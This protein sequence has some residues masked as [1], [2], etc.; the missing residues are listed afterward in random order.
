MLTFDIETTGTKNEEVIKKL[1]ESIRPP[2]S[3]KK[4]ESIDKW[5]EENY[6]QALKDKIADTALSGMYGRVTCIAWINDDD[7][8]QSTSIYTNEIE[9]INNFYA[10]IDT[11]GND[12]FCGH[13]IHGFD[14]QFLKQRSI[15]LGI[16]PPK[17]LWKAMNAKPWDDCIK[18]TML[19]WSQDKNK[20]IGLDTLCW[21]L[22]IDRGDTSITG[23]ETAALWETGPQKVIDKCVNDVRKTVEVYNKLTFNDSVF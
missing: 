12:V 15:I 6:D 22:G 5:M 8:V 14:L 20:M 10:A 18:D 2:G 19:M 23:S 21:I 16:K 11:W 7:I 9:S 13:N 1:A 3:I 4:Q 17:S